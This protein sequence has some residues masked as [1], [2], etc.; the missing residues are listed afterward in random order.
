MK[1]VVKNYKN[2]LWATVVALVMVLGSCSKS[3]DL[4]P[5]SDND[6]LKLKTG[7]IPNTLDCVPEMEFTLWAGNGTNPQNVA[8]TLIVSN[9]E[10]NLYVEFVTTSS[11]TMRTIHLWVGCNPLDVPHNKKGI[12]VPGQFPIHQNP[13]DP[14]YSKV[15]IPLESLTCLGKDFCGKEIYVFAHVETAK[16]TLW[17]GDIAFTGPRWGWYAKYKI[18]CEEQPPTGGEECENETAFG[19]NSE[20]AGKAWWYYYSAGC[21]VQTIWAG[22]SKEAGSVVIE[23]GV[24]TI[25]LKEGWSLQNVAEPVKIQGYTTLP[26]VRPAAGQ[27]T[28]YKGSNLINISVGVY[29]YYVIHLDLKYCCVVSN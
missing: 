24:A 16:E 7:N 8:G 29:A 5:L 26:A 10:A 25:T 12:P 28:T 4:A 13:E 1:N 21:G 9:D 15:T 2:S 14:C 27:F 11:F 20:G 22:Q 18:C 23:N 6:N 17:G 19:G 3:N